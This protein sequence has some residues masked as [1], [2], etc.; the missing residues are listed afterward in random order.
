MLVGRMIKSLC[1]TGSFN[2]YAADGY[3][4]R[5]LR[6]RKAR[7]VLAFDFEQGEKID[8]SAIVTGNSRKPRAAGNEEKL[9]VNLTKSSCE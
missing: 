4:I 9:V 3:D 8:E 7:H 5:T 2:V 1:I 6:T